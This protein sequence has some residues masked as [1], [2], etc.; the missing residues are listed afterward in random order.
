M[1]IT[2]PNPAVDEQDNEYPNVLIS[3]AIS[4]Q[5]VGDNVKA[6]VALKCVPYRI[7]D[8]EIIQHPSKRTF[9]TQDAFAQATSDPAL[10][11]AVTVIMGA[12]QGFVTAKNL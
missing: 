11:E 7:E 1:P 5:P 6:S 10:A 2:T 12:V 8:G 9:V 3:L 4:G